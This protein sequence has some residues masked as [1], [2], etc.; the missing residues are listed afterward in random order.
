MATYRVTL[1][2]SWQG[3]GTDTDPFRPDIQDVQGWVDVTGQPLANILPAPNAV[4]I[5]AIV[6]DAQLALL[7]QDDIL[8]QETI[9]A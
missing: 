2:T 1:M 7:D 9:N 8:T 3:T 6:N 4:V 5:A